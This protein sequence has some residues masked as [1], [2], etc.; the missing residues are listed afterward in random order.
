MIFAVITGYIQDGRECRG[1]ET[2]VERAKLR[3][4][5]TFGLFLLIVSAV[6]VTV[7]FM[8][9]LSLMQGMWLLGKLL[10]GSANNMARAVR[11]AFGSSRIAENRL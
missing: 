10:V 9:E 5:G 1:T 2:A 11:V 4:R 3:P 8:K 7:N 6:L